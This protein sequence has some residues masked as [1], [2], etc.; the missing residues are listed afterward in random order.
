MI[1]HLHFDGIAKE[2]KGATKIAKN[3]KHKLIT[4]IDHLKHIRS[5]NVKR[6]QRR[7]DE[8]WID[9]K[10]DKESRKRIVTPYRKTRDKTPALQ[11]SM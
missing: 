9:R 2:N 3:I 1:L 5:N 7:L 11:R 10:F 8:S 4:T 6:R